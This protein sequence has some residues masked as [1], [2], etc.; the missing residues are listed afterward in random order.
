MVLVATTAWKARLAPAWLPVLLFAGIVV[1]FA[2]PPAMVVISS[3]VIVI[4][5]AIIARGILRR[6]ARGLRPV[7]AP[8]AA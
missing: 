2:G 5:Y 4:A 3:V 8:A 1:S 6:P 7:A